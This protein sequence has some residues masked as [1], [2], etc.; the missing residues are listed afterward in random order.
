MTTQTPSALDARHIEREHQVQLRLMQAVEATLVEGKDVSEGIEALADYS[1]AHFLSEELLMR[2]YEYADY[3]DHIL[4]HER[5]L[6]W[7]GELAESQADRE[8]RLHALIELKAL[9][10]RHIA[11]RDRQLH[12]FLKSL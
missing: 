3:D 8:S 1:R 7:L 2:Q 11:G 9:F 10:L 12:D 6:D 5:M 4:D